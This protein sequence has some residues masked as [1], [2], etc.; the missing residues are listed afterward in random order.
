MRLEIWMKLLSFAHCI[1][2]INWL[3]FINQSDLKNHFQGYLIQETMGAQ[4]NPHEC[5]NLLVEML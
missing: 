4:D 1:S 2:E 3:I 5:Y